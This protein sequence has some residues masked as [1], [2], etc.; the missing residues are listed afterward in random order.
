MD[1]VD[2]LPQQ[3]EKLA[4]VEAVIGEFGV[5]SEGGMVALVFW[6]ELVSSL[7]GDVLH[8]TQSCQIQVAAGVFAVKDLE[9]NAPV[10]L[11]KH[12]GE[13]SSMHSNEN[14]GVGS[15]LELVHEVCG[16]AK[17]HQTNPDPWK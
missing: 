3:P 15:H 10:R 17:V 11:E 9:E 6:V 12:V 13:A 5:G 14:I 16:V 1:V 7:P 4:D 8:P 2:S